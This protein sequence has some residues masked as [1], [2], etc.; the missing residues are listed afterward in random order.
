MIKMYSAVKEQMN[1]ALKMKQL[2]I[3]PKK[4]D[5]KKFVEYVSKKLPMKSN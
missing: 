5:L 4:K 1:F 2:G 3:E